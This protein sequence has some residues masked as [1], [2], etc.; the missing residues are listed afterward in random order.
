MNPEELIRDSFA[1]L[2]AH[3]E[4]RAYKNFAADLVVNGFLPEPIGLQEFMGL[5]AGVLGAFPDWHFEIKQVQTQGDKTTVNLQVSGT[6]N[7]PLMLPGMP[8]IPASGKKVSAPD[9]FI[10]TVGSDNMLH[11]MDFDTPPGGG[12]AS[13]L[14]QLGVDMSGMH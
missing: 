6:Q 11:Q 14:M 3:D 12:F 2:N 13:V 1:G 7:G 9:R 4:K 5:N 10:C 8:E